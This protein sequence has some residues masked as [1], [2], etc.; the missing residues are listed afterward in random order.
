MTLQNLSLVEMELDSS[1]PTHQ[2]LLL[3]VDWGYGYKHHT[4]KLQ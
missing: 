2:T 4:P 3:A 1:G